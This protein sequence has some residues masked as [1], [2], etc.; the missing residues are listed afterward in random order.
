METGSDPGVLQDALR[1]LGALLQ[2]KALSSSSNIKYT[3]HWNQWEGFCKFMRWSSWIEVDERGGIGKLGQFA[4]YCW[5]FGFNKQGIGNSYST[6][7]GKLSSIRW[8]H[9][10]HIGVDIG[11]S[12]EF[13]IM[14]QG[15]R[16]FS[17]PV[18]KMHPLTVKILHTIRSLLNLQYPGHRLMWGTIL[19]GFFFLLRRSEYLKIGGKRHGYCLNTKQVW[20]SDSDGTKTSFKEATSVSIFLSGAKNDQYGRGATRTMHKSGDDQ[21]CPVQALRHIRKASRGR[22]YAYATGEIKSAAVAGIIKLAAKK[23]GFETKNYST[24][25]VRIGGATALLNAGVDRLA[26]KLL[27]RWLSS[28][29]EDY[30]VQEARGT[31][32]LATAMVQ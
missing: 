29:F 31:K 5:K 25:S 7:Q 2:D 23:L 6:I 24:H 32:K 17:D 28:C 11:C 13:V 22:K 9:R 19:L 4:V 21:I 15:I 16:R 1:N 30:P 8:M 10:R 26:I 12:P 20:F 18:R 14:L 3:R 27:G